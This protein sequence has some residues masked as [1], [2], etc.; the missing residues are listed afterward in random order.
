MP[1]KI[2]K[3]LTKVNKGKKGDNHPE[4]IIVH[5]V[6]AAG[7]A[8]GNAEYF[9][10]VYRGASA[11]YFVDPKTIVQ[12]VE[13]DTPAWH[14]GDGH[15]TGKG[16]K[17]GYHKKGGATNTNSIGIEGCQDTSTG[18]D[19]W[20]WAFHPDTVK[21]IEW[22]VRKLQKQYNI[23]DAH[24]IR[25]YDATGKLCPGNWSQNN[26][27]G[28]K[29]FKATLA[30][31]IVQVKPV[32]NPRPEGKP[33]DDDM[34]LVEPGDTLYSIAKE[35][36]VSVEDLVKWNKLKNPE[37]IIPETK[38]FL[39]MERTVEK[40]VTPVSTP[41]VA[42]KPAPVAPKKSVDELAREVLDGRHGSGDVRRRALGIQYDAVQ[43]R[44]NELA[45]GKATSKPAPAKKS[46]DQ[47]AKEVMDGKHG[48]GDARKKSLG[49]QYDAVQDRVNE[50]LAP[51]KGKTIEQLA[52]EVVRGVHGSGRDRMRSLGTQYTAV[53][54]LVNR[55][56]R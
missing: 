51:K 41:T 11:Q 14:I 37:V 12:V 47:L 6:G 18:K 32:S 9:E 3:H 1:Y 38:L 4:Y 35:H 26:W 17:N 53:Q 42:P 56:S 2:T 52:D 46:V 15:R 16:T 28:W 30:K 23:D 5:F 25:H 22:L 7:Q 55:R 43:K 20:T 39:S 48:G 31:D 33:F 24:V 50:L 54:Q 44:V 8:M 10:E 36:K 19:V 49:S 27:K 40:P 13:D 34:Y 21:R 29:D 45:G